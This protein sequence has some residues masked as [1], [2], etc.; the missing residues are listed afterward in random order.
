MTDKTTPLI[1]HLLITRLTFLTLDL[2]A[3]KKDRTLNTTS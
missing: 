3:L 2:S 1:Q